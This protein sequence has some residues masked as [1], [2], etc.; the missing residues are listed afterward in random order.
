MNKP[1]VSYLISYTPVKI[2]EEVLLQVRNPEGRNELR[3][4]SPVIDMIRR[5]NDGRPVFET[6][7]TIYVPADVQ[8]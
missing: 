3:I 2:G 4:T 5:E 6:L 1:L 7:N 8:G